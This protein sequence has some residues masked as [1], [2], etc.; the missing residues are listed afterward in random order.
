MIK[1]YV[2]ERK[3]WI[4][5]FIFVQVLLLFIAYIDS[6]IPFMPILYIVF[7]SMI[8]FTHLFNHSLQQRNEIL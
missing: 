2:M 5:L 3:S 7:L 8:L 4:L 6:A 1:K